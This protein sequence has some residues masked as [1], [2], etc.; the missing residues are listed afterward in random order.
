MKTTNSTIART[1]VYYDPLLLRYARRIINDAAVA[2]T[3]VKKVLED[4]YV[5]DGLRPSPRLRQILKT[6]L[7]NRCHYWKQSQI[8]DR[9]LIKVPLLKNAMP[10]ENI[11]HNKNHR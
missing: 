4:Q 10:F 11:D 3:L 7:L 9:Q 2:E 6:D 8:F 1:I 5:I